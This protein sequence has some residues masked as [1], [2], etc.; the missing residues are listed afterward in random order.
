MLLSFQAEDTLL[1]V[2]LTPVCRCPQVPAGGSE[3]MKDFPAL[4][5]QE[6]RLEG[7]GHLEAAADI[8]LSSAGKHVI[9][10]RS[11]RDKNTINT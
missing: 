7:R 6:F 1:S 8:K 4:V 3:R 5:P 11:I 9:N 10:K 2:T